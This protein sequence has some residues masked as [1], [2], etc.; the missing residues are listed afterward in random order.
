MMF[1]AIASINA[2]IDRKALV[3]RNCVAVSGF[4]SLSSL[5]IGNGGFAMTVDATGLQSFPE[6]YKNGCPLGTQSEWGWHS[7]PNTQGYKIEESYIPSNF[8]GRD[9]LYATQPKSPQ[10]AAEAANYFRNNPHRLH[11]GYLGIRFSGQ[12]MQSIGQDEITDIDQTLDLWSGS[13]VSKYKANGEPVKVVTS[14]HPHK[15]LIAAEIET[16]L[17]GKQQLAITLTFPFPTGK[18]ADDASDFTQP[19]KHQTIIV[20][21]SKQFAVVQRTIDTTVYYVGLSW[22]GNATIEILE[23]H[24]VVLKPKSGRIKVKCQFAPSRQALDFRIKYKNSLSATANYWTGFWTKGAVVDF[25]SCKDARAKELERRVVLSQYLMAIQCSGTVPPQETGLTYNSW[26]GRPHLEMHWWHASHFALWNHPELLQRSFDWYKNTAFPIAKNIAQRQGFEGVRW[27]KM[28]DPW[29]NEAPSR[30]GSYLIWQQPHF[31]YMAELVYRATGDAK[32]LETY[33]EQVFESA[34]FMASFVTYDATNDRYVIKGAIPAQE[35][36]RASETV[37]PPFE[38]SYWHFALQT[39]QQ[40]RKRLGLPVEPKWDE[41]VAKIS[42]LA[43]IDGQ[44]LAAETALDTYSDIRFTSDHPAVL[45]ALGILPKSPLVDGAIMQNTLN[46]IWANWN[47]NKTWGWDF[48]MVAM[49]AARL[50]D[51]QKAVDALLMEKRTNTYLPNGHNYQDERLQ[52]YLP[53][54]GGLLTA[55]AMMCAGWDGCTTPNPGFPKD[56]NWE[57]KWEGLR[58]LP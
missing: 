53:G 55:I 46:W 30:V 25:S 16:P 43:H 32:L 3:K 34:N 15:D 39:A 38:L 41:V 8:R 4:D 19:S 29:A 26:F 49:N 51:A 31:I 21:K 57:V 5:S 35:T 54:N 37:N 17:I 24:C 36:L 50:G 18:H 47:W 27:M 22:E 20:E 40:W 11:L 33:K 44:Y 12:D 45:G 10:Q 9:E 6:F 48:P 7:F 23:P 58:P 13:I 14:C 1:G 42:P 52:V 2:P 56:G 28:T